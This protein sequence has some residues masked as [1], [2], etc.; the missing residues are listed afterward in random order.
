MHTQTYLPTVT[1]SCA[2]TSHTHNT[3]TPKH[4]NHLACE[5]TNDVADMNGEG[6]MLMKTANDAN[7]GDITLMPP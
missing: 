1:C 4:N 7:H 6:Y 2:H 3:F 5:C